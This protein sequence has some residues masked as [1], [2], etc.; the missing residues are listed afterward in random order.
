MRPGTDL[1]GPFGGHVIGVAF[2]RFD[3]QVERGDVVDV[4]AT[5]D[6]VENAVGVDAAADHQ[7][8]ALVIGPGR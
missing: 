7:L 4:F 1:V 6:V 2:A 5:I 8:G 3:E